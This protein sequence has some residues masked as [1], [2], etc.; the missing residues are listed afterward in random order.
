MKSISTIILKPLKQTQVKK[1]KSSICDYLAISTCAEPV[2]ENCIESVFSTQNLI[3]LSNI[4]EALQ[5]PKW[6]KSMDDEYEVLIEKKVWEVVLP[7]PD[8]NIVGSCWTHICKFNKDRTA[9]AKS[10]W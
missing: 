3:I 10:K 8:T 6:K 9:M 7:P 1:N 4:D 2:K 5:D